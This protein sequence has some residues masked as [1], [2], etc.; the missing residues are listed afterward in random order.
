MSTSSAHPNLNGIIAGEN[1]NGWIQNGAHLN[2]T[3][4]SYRIGDK[5]NMD[6]DIVSAIQ[7]G[8]NAW[9]FVI[10]INEVTTGGLGV[11]QFMQSYNFPNNAAE[12]RI[13]HTNGH[14]TSFIIALNPN[15]QQHL[16]RREILAHEFGH[17]IGLNELGVNLTTLVAIPELQ[18]N[19]VNVMYGSTSMT[20]TGPTP[21]DRGGAMVI[22]GQ[23]ST[24][25]WHMTHYVSKTTTV[26]G[27]VRNMHRSVCDECN[28]S[29]SGHVAA[30]CTYNGNGM[31]CT[32]CNFSR[33]G[34]AN[35]DG[36]RDMNDWFFITDIA[37]G[38]LNPT[39]RQY[40]FAD[41]DG[42]GRITMNDA[43]QLQFFLN[44]MSSILE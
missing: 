21:R 7:N 37:A 41:I 34:D 9:R 44:N 14:I 40:Y 27:K 25:Y 3:S 23:H 35:Q 16:K 42:D 43:Q 22:T 13:S 4:F 24:H 38:R 2:G 18:Y 30:A 32:V 29:R 15:H 17:V 11:V 12:A 28:G 39:W 6:P 5:Q 33:N 31:R 8:A 19:R 1:S 20:A 26:V 36:R 10:S